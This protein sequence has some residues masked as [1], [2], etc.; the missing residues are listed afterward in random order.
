MSNEKYENGFIKE[1]NN[2]TDI[3]S[4]E[5]LYFLKN[6]D[7]FHRQNLQYGFAKKCNS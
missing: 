1:M 4:C 2:L 3:L 6:K 7:D 5:E